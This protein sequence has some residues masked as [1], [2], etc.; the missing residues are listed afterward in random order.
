M[1]NHFFIKL[2]FL[3]YWKDIVNISDTNQ[4]FSEI[5]QEI[6]LTADKKGYFKLSIRS[7][8]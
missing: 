4:I 2:A 3:P 5:E 7:G 1:F 6:N 8:S